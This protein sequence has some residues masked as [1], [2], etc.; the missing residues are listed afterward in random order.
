VS[1]TRITAPQFLP[2]HA[3]EAAD[4]LRLDESQ[5]AVVETLI[6]A[7][8]EYLDGYTGALGR[9]LVSQVWEQRLDRFPIADW[10]SVRFCSS[11]AIPLPPL[12]SV[13]Y[14]KYF[15]AAGVEQTWPTTEYTVDLPNSLV[16]LAFE[17]TWPVTR[18]IPNAVTIRFVSGYSVNT[19]PAADKALVFQKVAKWH[20][21]REEM[22]RDLFSAR[23]EW[24]VA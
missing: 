9:A 19:L 14:I 7:A 2:I 13:T 1:L 4:W 5:T 24:R 3:A 12:A 20:E 10:P 15:D 22:D 21:D 18:A 17:K 16:H 11:I 8:T 6:Q 23:R